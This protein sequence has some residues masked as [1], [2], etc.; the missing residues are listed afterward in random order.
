MPE[1]PFSRARRRECTA[2]SADRSQHQPR[3]DLPRV[4]AKNAERRVRL[5]AAAVADLF[6][7]RKKYVGATTNGVRN[8]RAPAEQSRKERVGSGIATRMLCIP[9][10]RGNIRPGE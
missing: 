4:L 2:R 5:V 8:E 1:V 6:G 7:R 9:L 3:R 10:L